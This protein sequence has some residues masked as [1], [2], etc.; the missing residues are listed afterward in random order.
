MEDQTPL[1]LTIQHQRELIG[2]EGIEIARLVQREKNSNS[3]K[4]KLSRYPRSENGL[5]DQDAHSQV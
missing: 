1:P 4:M 2:A 3:G 5:E